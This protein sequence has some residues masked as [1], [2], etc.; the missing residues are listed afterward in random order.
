MFCYCGKSETSVLERVSHTPGDEYIKWANSAEE[1]SYYL[2]YP[3][4]YCGGYTNTTA[5][6][7]DNSEV[8][9]DNSTSLFDNTVFPTGNTTSSS[10]LVYNPYTGWSVEQQCNCP[11]CKLDRA[12]PDPQPTLPQRPSV[13]TVDPWKKQQEAYAKKNSFVNPCHFGNSYLY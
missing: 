13:P 6:Y 11:F 8:S 2:I 10:N 3:C 5:V 12:L 4:I 7:E 1:G 9:S